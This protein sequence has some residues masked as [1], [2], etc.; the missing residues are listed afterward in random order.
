MKYHF[1]NCKGT[2]I[3]ARIDRLLRKNAYFLCLLVNRY[4][5]YLERKKMDVT[6]Q[7]LWHPNSRYPL[8][9]LET[10]R[11]VRRVRAVRAV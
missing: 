1:S 8:T 10:T 11:V 2:K 6:E 4:C 9:R 5:S 7:Y 3:P